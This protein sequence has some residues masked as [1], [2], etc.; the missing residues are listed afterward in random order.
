MADRI[1]PSAKPAANGATN[2][3]TNGGNPAFPATKA[4]LYGATRGA[5]RPQPKRHRYRRS[6]CCSCCLWLTLAIILILILAA[7]AG[8]IVYVLYR[9][10]RPTFT[11]S[12]LKIT[13]LNLTSS[14]NLVT[15]IQ[16]N[17]TAK[18]PNKKLVFYYDPITVSLTTNDDI[19]IGDG[20]FPAFEHGTKNTTLIKTSIKSSG[21]QL[22]D[23]SA[24]SLQSQLKKKN[25]F[26]LK[27]KIETKVKVKMGAIKSPKVQI[28]VSCDGIKA[29]VPTGKTATSAT[30]AKAKCKVDWRIK[31]WKWTF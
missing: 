14:S 13:T 15:N 29:S 9:P 27:V 26:P 8:A 22:D 20:T 30:T 4:Q 23:A 5:Y 1:Y 17:V 7:I 21:K 28:R 19:P 11:V 10:H 6:C 18:N 12:A 31:I 3:T 24:S 16:L 2:G 25:D